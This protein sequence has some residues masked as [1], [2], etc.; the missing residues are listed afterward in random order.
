VGKR[1]QALRHE[2]FGALVCLIALINVCNRLNV[3]IR[4]P[5]GDYER[6]G[7]DERIARNRR[8]PVGWQ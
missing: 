5:A 8:R 6:A 4:Q 3:I 7:G 2:R 1:G